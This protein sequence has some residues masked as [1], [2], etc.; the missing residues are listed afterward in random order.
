MNEAV[1]SYIIIVML[2]VI[3][4]IL[5]VKVYDNR[6][7]ADTTRDYDTNSERAYTEAQ[8]R[9]EGALDTVKHIRERQ[10]VEE[11]HHHR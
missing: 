8:N 5:G 4:G 1:I 6:K 10:K 3:S 9:A 2:S 11:Q 7:S